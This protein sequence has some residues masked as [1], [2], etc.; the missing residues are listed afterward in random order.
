M[1]GITI[2]DQVIH[3]IILTDYRAFAGSH[4]FEF[5]PGVNVI[6][7]ANGSG[8]SSLVQSVFDGTSRAE[9]EEGSQRV[10]E[11]TDSPPSLVEIEFSCDD[12]RFLLRKVTGDGNTTTHSLVK[13]EEE[14]VILHG[15][16]ALRCASGLLQPIRFAPFWS[17]I[18]RTEPRPTPIGR[19]EMMAQEWLIERWLE[20]L[21][22]FNRVGNVIV[23]GFGEIESCVDRT[24]R[25]RPL[26][27]LARGVTEI[28]WFL[29]RL[30]QLIVSEGGGH[31][32]RVVAIDEPLI[33]HDANL[34]EQAIDLLV[35]EAACRGTQFIIADAHRYDNLVVHGIELPPVRARA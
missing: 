18:R 5:E 34:R 25:R 21:E 32:E 24:G 12:D 19:I 35:R 29:Q 20:E 28:L 7:G 8:K 14:N 33:F 16:N 2:T 31:V 27:A 22:L 3:S 9:C 10:V 11:G 6:S 23:D 17:R 26:A 13:I 1:E 15:S 4:R 30:A